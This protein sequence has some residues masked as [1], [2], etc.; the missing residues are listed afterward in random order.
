MQL[1]FRSKVATA[2]VMVTAI[3]VGAVAVIITDGAE[4]EDIIMVGATIAITGDCVILLEPPQ[5]RPR[6]FSQCV[7]NR[8]L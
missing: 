3:W 6:S 1:S 2:T 5:W 8:K 7:P 4:A